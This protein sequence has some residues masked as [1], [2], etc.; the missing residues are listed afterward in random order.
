MTP[1]KKHYAGILWCQE[2]RIFDKPKPD[3]K[4]LALRKTSLNYNIREYFNKVL[5]DKILNPKKIDLIDIYKDF[6]YMNNEIDKSLSNGETL[7]LQPGKVNSFDSYAA[8]LTQQTVRGTL[9]WNALFPDNSIQPP[10]KVNYV[11]LKSINYKDFID[12]LPSEELKI[13][14]SNL[15]DTK[16]YTTKNIIDD[17]GKTKIIKGLKDYPIEIICVPKNIKKLPEFLIPLIDIDIMEHDHL[18]PCY[19]IIEPLGFKTLDI[20][21]NNFITNVILI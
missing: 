20:T 17:T 1:S 13:S 10:T 6:I 14:I 16:K 7:Y 2:G 19:E 18:R 8:P 15:Y 21:V 5:L 11:K 12:I 9:L 4:G 3:V